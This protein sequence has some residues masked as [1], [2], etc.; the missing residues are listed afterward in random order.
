M[1]GEGREFVMDY[2]FL[3]RRQ[4][5]TVVKKLSVTSSAAD[6]KFRFKSPYKMTDHGSLENGLNWAEGHVYYKEFRTVLTEAVAGFA[7]LYA[8]GVSKCTFHAGVKGRP[9]H[10][11]QDLEYPHPS[12]SIS[13]DNV[14]FH[15]TSF[16]VSHAHPKPRI[17]STIG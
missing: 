10:K 16:P 3:R 12:L 17:P 7:N 15:A 2:E 5:E 6:E 4:N 14:H 13:N 9:I 8:Y 1:A 11:L